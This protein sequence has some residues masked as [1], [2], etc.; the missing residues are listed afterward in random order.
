LLNACIQAVQEAKIQAGDE[1]LLVIVEV[2]SHIR[3]VCNGCARTL[4]SLINGGWGVQFKL[5][6]TR[7]GIEND[8][9]KFLLR[10]SA[11]ETF[12]GGGA[13]KGQERA[14]REEKRG[15]IHSYEWD[16]LPSEHHQLPSNENTGEM[17]RPPEEDEDEEEEDEDDSDD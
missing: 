15:Y 7:A 10:T 17:W 8:S 16:E 13:A 6:L 11:D 5:A 12:P 3:G 1:V 4:R 14:K 9:L 2:H